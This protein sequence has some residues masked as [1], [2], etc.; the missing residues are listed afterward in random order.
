MIAGRFAQSCSRFPNALFEQRPPDA[1]F[2]RQ[3]LL[4]QEAAPEWFRKLEACLQVHFWRPPL[5]VLTYD[6][7]EAWALARL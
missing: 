3:F 2:S 7:S 1:A 4:G 5:A 6:R